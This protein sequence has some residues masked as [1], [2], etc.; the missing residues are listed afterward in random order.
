MNESEDGS[1]YLFQTN[2]SKLKKVFQQHVT[3]APDWIVFVEFQKFCKQTQIF[4]NF[5][6][7]IQLKKIVE[8]TAKKPISITNSY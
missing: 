5:V 6:S 4:P 3:S 8:S 1:D 7:A 2:K